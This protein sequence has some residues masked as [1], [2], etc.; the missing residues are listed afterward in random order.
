MDFG[1]MVYGLGFWDWG[2][3][4]RVSQSGVAPVRNRRGEG[5]GGGFRD[6]N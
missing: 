6:G 3:W 1:C 2:F 5:E 4:F